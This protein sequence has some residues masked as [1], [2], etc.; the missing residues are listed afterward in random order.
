M[1]RPT[2]GPGS[3]ESDN[4]PAFSNAAATDP[5]EDHDKGDRKTKKAK[6]DFAL[7]RVD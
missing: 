7:E 6:E 2:S 3:A 4:P 5:I 1:G